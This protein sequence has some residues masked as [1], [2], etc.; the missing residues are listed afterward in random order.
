M[1]KLISFFF[2]TLDRIVLHLA[3]TSKDPKIQ[4]KIKEPLSAGPEM[5]FAFP[6]QPNIW[7]TEYR[8][9][10]GPRK[11]TNTIVHEAAHVAGVSGLLWFDV[12][13]QA[14]E[15]ASGFSR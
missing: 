14:I 1:W 10:Q 5:G 7:L 4:K 9:K 6:D 15:K 11:I 2:E 12:M 13:I 8:L 3:D